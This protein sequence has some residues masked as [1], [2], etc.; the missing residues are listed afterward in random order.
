MMKQAL[1]LGAALTALGLISSSAR[2]QQ[3]DL[4]R[5]SPLGKVSQVVGLTEI[6]VEYSSPSVRG[7][8]IWGTVVP[9][10]TLWRTGA[11]AATKITFSR[12][13][14]V[15]G[16]PVPAG[17]YALFTIPSKSEWTIILNKNAN[18]GG[19]NDYKEELDQV[20]WKAR[21]HA[22]PAREHLTF[23]FPDFGD[24]GATLELA[25]E[26]LA[27]PIPIGV[28]T[29]EQTHAAVEHIDDTVARMYISAARYMLEQ[30]KDYP[31]GL[32]LVDKSIALKDDWLGYWTKASLLAAQGKYKEAYPLAEKADALGQKVGGPGYFF[33][34]EVKKA[35]TDWKKKI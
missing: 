17:T 12:D 22:G 6:T 1:G 25:W 2:A 34:A 13:V 28:H 24:K 29:D 35:L 9:Y 33:Q 14:T 15:A 8:K 19:T 3:L 32:R 7:R 26:K 5:P 10:D 11:N 31:E 4:P 23:S 21:P 18:Q 30:K 20:R 27:L 16:K